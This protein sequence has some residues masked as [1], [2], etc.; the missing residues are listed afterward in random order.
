MQ[1]ETERLLLRPPRLADVLAL[2]A[3]LGDPIAMR[4]THVDADLRSCRRRV[5]VHER[6]RRRDGYAPWTVL[7]R[8]H[9]RIIGWGGLYEDPFEPGW[10]VEVGYFF[11]PAVWGRGLASEL[12]AA[13]LAVADGLALPE[14]RAFA[15]PANTASR[16]VLEQAGFTRDRCLPEMDRFLFHRRRPAPG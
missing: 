13:A 12:L 8:V 5:A 6:R 3:F 9:G 11:H 10:G 7:D 16:R 1:V 14:V 15:H 2:F 4:H